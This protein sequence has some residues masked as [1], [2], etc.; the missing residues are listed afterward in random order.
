MRRDSSVRIGTHH[1][2]DGPGIESRWGGGEILRTRLDRPWGPSSILHNG[3]RIFLGG[4]AAW[5]WCWRPTPSSADVKER[6]ELYFYSP[7]GL[8]GLFEGELYLYLY[9]IHTYSAVQKFNSWYSTVKHPKIKSV[10][11]NLQLMWSNPNAY[12]LLSGR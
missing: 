4:K 12:L 8:R 1:W 9:S 5:A 11:Y 7:L 6:A 10:H 3:Y 2:L